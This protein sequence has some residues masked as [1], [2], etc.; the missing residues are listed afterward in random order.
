MEEERL[1]TK[2]SAD[3]QKVNFSSGGNQ[4]QRAT[5][6][7]HH[8]PVLRSR[9]RVLVVPCLLVSWQ[10][11]GILANAILLQGKIWEN[12]THVDRFID[13]GVYQVKRYCA[14]Y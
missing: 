4:F 6:R 13:T 3:A 11:Q 2:W 9:G 8:L 5:V 10:T 7:P 1:I 12:I 14:S